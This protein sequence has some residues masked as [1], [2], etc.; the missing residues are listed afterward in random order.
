[1]AINRNLQFYGFAYGDTPVTLDVKINGQQVFLNTVSTIPGSMP[2][3]AYSTVCNQ[4]L[5]EVNDTSLF[6]VTFS[7]SY[8]HS[9]EVSGGQGILISLVKSNWMRNKVDNVLYA[10]NATGFVH[11]YS[12]TPTNSDNNSD[13]RSNVKIDGVAPAETTG[14]GTGT[15]TWR[16][17]NGSNL[18]CNLNI[19]TGNTVA[20]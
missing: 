5:F 19:G 18:T 4:L 17:D 8:D 9:I 16:V 10:G 3:D 15:W 11:V 7:G 12:G 2:E 6:P 14:S 13:V 20:N 1:M